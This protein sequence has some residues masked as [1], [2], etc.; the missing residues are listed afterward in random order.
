MTISYWMKGSPTY[1]WMNPL[2][3]NNGSVGWQIQVSPSEAVGIRIDTSAGSNQ[4]AYFNSSD[5]FFDG[6]WHYITITL[7]SG[8]II[9]YKDGAPDNTGTYQVGGGFGSPS[10]GLIF[11]GY[12]FVGALDEAAIWNTA[13]TAAQ[14]QTIYQHE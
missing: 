7:N 5:N 2:E 12:Q 13:L 9:L 8:N 6:N 10:S 1:T 14:I 11:Q 4:C 3:K